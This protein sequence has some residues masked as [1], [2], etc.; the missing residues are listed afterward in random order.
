MN[1]VRLRGNGGAYSSTY[2]QLLRELGVYG[3]CFPKHYLK[4]G[5]RH[6]PVPSG[7]TEEWGLLLAAALPVV[8]FL[9][10]LAGDLVVF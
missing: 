7:F 10:V 8:W 2:S 1:F 3:T 4:M 5:R 6:T 9:S